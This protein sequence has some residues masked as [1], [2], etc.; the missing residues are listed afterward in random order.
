MELLWNRG[1]QTYGKKG[2]R[3]RFFLISLR[4]R[5]NVDLLKT[6]QVKVSLNLVLG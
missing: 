6:S 4:Q 2:N 5:H 3:T 1:L